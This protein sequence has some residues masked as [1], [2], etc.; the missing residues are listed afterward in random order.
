MLLLVRK[1]GRRGW[2]S[3]RGLWWVDAVAVHACL[4]IQEV[5]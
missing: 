1:R 2:W 5:S 3:V 4:R